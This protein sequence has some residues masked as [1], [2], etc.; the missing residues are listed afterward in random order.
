MKGKIIILFILSCCVFDHV[1]GQEYQFE[2]NGIM[3]RVIQDP[4]EAAIMG[5][6][7]VTANQDNP[8]EGSIVIPA[9]ITDGNEKNAD[10]YSVVGIDDRAFSNCSGL[11]SVKLPISVEHI[12]K[13][14]FEGCNNL[15]TVEIPYG[16]MKT[17]DEY[18]FYESGIETISIP[19]CIRKIEES[20]FCSCPKL[21]EVNFSDGLTTIGDGAF[22]YCPSLK[23]VELPNTLKKLANNAFS[24]CEHLEIVVLPET[25]K[26]IG[27]S[28]FFQCERLSTI[29]IP[30]SVVFIGDDA[31]S[32]CTSL[33][34]IVNK[35]TH[36]NL[37]SEKEKNRI[38]CSRGLFGCKNM[39]DNVKIVD[40][41]KQ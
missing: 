41:S 37:T 26:S 10:R 7:N 33:N 35:S 15:R 13:F 22:Y 8:Y 21:R 24:K 20:A 1:R 14:A 16:K 39:I 34:L 31:F 18:A 28:A 6:V 32:C 23:Q 40:D 29:T 2:K 30:P 17:I 11:T 3:F 25:L 38:F 5:K 4:T 19:S 12:G 9:G 27:E 36:I